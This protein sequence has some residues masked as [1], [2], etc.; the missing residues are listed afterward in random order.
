MI[1]FAC[2][3]R[4]VW[5]T[6]RAVIAAIPSNNKKLSANRQKLYLPKKFLMSRDVLCSFAWQWT[7]I[8]QKKNCERD[9]Q[10][11]WGLFKGWKKVFCRNKL[12]LLLQHWHPQRESKLSTQRERIYLFGQTAYGYL[13]GK[14]I[15]SFNCSRWGLWWMRK[16]LFADDVNWWELDR[17][18]RTEKVANWPELHLLTIHSYL[19]LEF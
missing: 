4:P 18:F 3:S 2:L 17:N 8:C 10:Q 16:K 12:Q 7:I 14:Y 11:Q 1:Q 15:K 13:N 5:Q 9:L 19:Y 6:N